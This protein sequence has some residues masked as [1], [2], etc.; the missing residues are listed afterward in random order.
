MVT[1]TERARLPL[2]TR[3]HNSGERRRAKRSR[4]STQVFFRPSSFE[5]AVGESPSSSASEATTRASSMPLVVLRG[6]FAA[7]IRALRAMPETGSTTTGT[8]L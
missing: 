2:S 6:E 4:R 3:W 5:I 1:A 8:S 7:R